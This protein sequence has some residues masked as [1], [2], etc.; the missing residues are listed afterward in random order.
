MDD[1]DSAYG[2][3]SYYID[4][5]N[6]ATSGMFLFYQQSLYGIVYSYDADKITEMGGKRTIYDRLVKKLNIPDELRE[7]DNCWSSDNIQEFVWE[8]KKGREFGLDIRKNGIVIIIAKNQLIVD[9]IKKVKAEK[10]NVGF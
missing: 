3:S 10:A 2:S 9:K 5:L 1:N 8:F 4:S 6:G 7:D